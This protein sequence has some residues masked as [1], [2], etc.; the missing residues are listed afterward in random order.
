MKIGTLEVEKQQEK[1]LYKTALVAMSVLA[2]V[3]QLK[4]YMLSVIY[5]AQV[6]ANL[7]VAP[8]IPLTLLL[9]FT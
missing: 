2:L 3:L 8:L 7:L 4:N 6:R 9:A 5:I 1:L